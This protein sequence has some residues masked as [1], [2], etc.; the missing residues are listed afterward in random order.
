[1]PQRNDLRIVGIL[2]CAGS[3]QRMGF[4]KLLTPIVGKTAIERSMDALIA[5]GVTELVFAVNDT[6]RAFVETLACPVPHRIVTGGATRRESVKQALESGSGDIA[7][8]HDA[9]RCLV[10][11]AIVQESIESARTF[12]S[13]VVAL[14]VTDT[15]FRMEDDTPQLIPREG[16]YR[17]QTPQTF[18][19]GEILAA[20][21]QQSAAADAAT[22]DCTLYA[23]A[24]HCPHLVVGSEA[25]FKLTVPADFARAQ[26]MLARYGTGFDTHRLVEGRRLILGGVD[27]PFE[28]GLLGHS[29]ADVLAHAIMDALL[30]A[31]GLPDIGHLFPDTDPAFKGADSMQLLARV[32]EAIREKGLSP[33]Q[34]SATILAQRPKMAPHLQN[35]RENFA[36]V[37]KIPVSEVALAATTTEGMNDEGRGLC[38]SVHAI[39][40]V[41]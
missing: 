34:C 15:V 26:Q 27:I 5:G 29:D 39:A 40:C 8:I 10:S 9:A 2:L 24:G 12:G 3:A 37:L 41:G 22:D 36:A 17:M 7:V 35:M 6:T 16:L 28:K 32:V 11:P 25:N 38:I 33:R 1:M 20:Y 30:G 13:G 23:L 31:A 4:D 21:A 18:R 19:Y 14:P